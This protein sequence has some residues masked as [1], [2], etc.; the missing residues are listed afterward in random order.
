MAARVPQ[1]VTLQG[2]QLMGEPLAGPYH[3]KLAAL[4]A[5]EVADVFL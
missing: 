4:W 2:S 3:L 5:V 1:M